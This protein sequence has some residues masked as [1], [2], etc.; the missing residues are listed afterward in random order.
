MNMPSTSS[1]SSTIRRDNNSEQ[2]ISDLGYADE[3][4]S[5][6][7][8]STALLSSGDQNV[9]ESQV[10]KPAKMTPIPKLQLATVCLI[11]LLDPIGFTQLFPYINQM[12]VDLNV[13]DDPSKVGFISGLVVST[14]DLDYCQSISH[15]VT[16]RNRPLLS[17]S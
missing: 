17:P 9:V 13:L 7:N 1:P 12:L 5:A 4:N 15:P 8:E 2:G 11:R 10:S 16:V 3:H 14:I 6:P